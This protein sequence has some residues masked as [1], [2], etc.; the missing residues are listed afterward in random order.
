MSPVAHHVI[1]IGPVE[2]DPVGLAE[3]RGQSGGATSGQ[4]A[5]AST[6]SR[7]RHCGCSSRFRF[8][9]RPVAGSVRSRA[10]RL[11]FLLASHERF[12]LGYSA[13]SAWTRRHRVTDERARR[14]RTSARRHGRAESCCFLARR[15]GSEPRGV[16]LL[17]RRRRGARGAAGCSFFP[18]RRR[19]RR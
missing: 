9:S 15:A 8:M 6:A 1:P 11:L 14:R 12:A 4:P 18:S 3:R 19:R 2:P 10:S 7:H 13:L 16:R 17:R 5:M